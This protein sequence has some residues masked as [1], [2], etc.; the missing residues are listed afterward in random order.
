[1]SNWEAIHECQDARGAEHIRKHNQ[2][3][4]KSGLLTSTLA[5]SSEDI[6]IDIDYSFHKTN[7]RDVHLN[8]VLSLL[9]YSNWFSTGESYPHVSEHF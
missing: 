2:V 9:T 8:N 4:N 7:S 3:L 1:M 6:E 5:M